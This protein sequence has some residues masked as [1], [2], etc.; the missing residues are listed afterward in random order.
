[1]T[2]NL[3]SSLLLFNSH[4]PPHWFLHPKVATNLPAALALN[5]CILQKTEIATWTVQV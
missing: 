2:A 5:C 3:V 1:M 4:A